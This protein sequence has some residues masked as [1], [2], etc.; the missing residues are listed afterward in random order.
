MVKRERAQNWVRFALK[1]GLLATDASVWEAMHHL[2]DEGSGTMRTAFHRADKLGEERGSRRSWSHSS[3]LLI[4]LG[5]GVGLGLLFA[6]VSG[7]EAR[8]AIRDTASNVKTKV[9][10]AAARVGWRNSPAARDY[11]LYAN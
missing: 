1:C 5:I 7:E 2:L 9:G 6:P 8:D 3:T 11:A 10:D 4:G